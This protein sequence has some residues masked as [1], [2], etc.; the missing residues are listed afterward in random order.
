MQ[1]LLGGSSVFRQ[2]Y[3]GGGNTTTPYFQTTSAAPLYNV[4]LCGDYPGSCDTGSVHIP[5]GAV[6]EDG[7][8]HHLYI[9][10]L[11]E[12]VDWSFW[13]SP[14]PSGTG[15]NFRP[16]GSGNVESLNAS[17][18]GIGLGGTAGNISLAWSERPED[19]L[20]G[21]IP[22][23]L[24]L[25]VTCDATN[26]GQHGSYVYP[27]IPNDHGGAT[28]NNFFCGTSAA[29]GSSD[30]EYV[31]WSNSSVNLQ[32]GAHLWLDESVPSAKRNTAGCD[33]IA[34]AELN[35]LNEFGGYV[36]DVGSAQ[37]FEAP[38]F[39]NRFAD[40][41]D[42]YDGNPNG[43]VSQ[44]AKVAAQIGEPSSPGSGWYYNVTNCGINLAQHLHVLIPPAVN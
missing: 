30:Q 13:I 27:V 4:L 10:D 44:W 31:A 38:I 22:H 42:T 12:G 34:Y 19:V 20:A 28:D 2:N 24:S 14:I 3:N 6:P 21:R 35:A 15:G 43:T 7:F 16:T 8:D 40:I 23:A 1:M 39:V 25:R 32:Y 5:T 9:R 29:N 18:E 11:S 17:G 26:D 37:Y 41:S 36:N 33:I